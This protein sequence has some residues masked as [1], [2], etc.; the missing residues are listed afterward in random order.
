MLS[1]CIFQNYVAEMSPPTSE[2]LPFLGAFFALCMCTCACLCGCHDAGVELSSSKL[3][4]A[5]DGRYVS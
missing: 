1:I 4:F 5:R 3:L 2:A